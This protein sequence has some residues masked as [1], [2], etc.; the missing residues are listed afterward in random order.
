MAALR[1]RT[2]RLLAKA[3]TYERGFPWFVIDIFTQ[4]QEQ[5]PDYIIALLLGYKDPPKD[6]V[7]PAGGNYN[8]YFPGHV[9]AMPNAARGRPGDL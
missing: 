2:F 1:R 9:I 3:R 6:F 7:L 4:Y 8:E 5:G